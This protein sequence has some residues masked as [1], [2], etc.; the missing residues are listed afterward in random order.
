MTKKVFSTECFTSKDEIQEFME[1][2]L[3]EL[4]KPMVSGV[5]EDRTP[6]TK[7]CVLKLS[8]E[9]RNVPILLQLTTLSNLFLSERN[10]MRPVYMDDDPYAGKD[11]VTFMDFRDPQKF[12]EQY[13]SPFY[14]KS[15]PVTFPPRYESMGSVCCFLP[16]RWMKTSETRFEFEVFPLE[17]W[18]F[19]GCFQ[20]DRL[21]IQQDKVA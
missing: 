10:E 21:I 18:K 19:G 20:L 2:K 8:F 6:T 16:T 9:L 13:K 17:E 5:I 3:I 4:L 12:G 11:W 15:I 1:T 14:M 7:D